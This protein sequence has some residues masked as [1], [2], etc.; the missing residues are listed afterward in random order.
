MQNLLITASVNSGGASNC[1]LDFWFAY[2]FE[3]VET[4]SGG[5]FSILHCYGCE[6]RFSVLDIA[7]LCPQVLGNNEGRGFGNL[8]VCPRS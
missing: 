8:S 3:K 1:L 5:S 6:G 7:R 2:W 4:S